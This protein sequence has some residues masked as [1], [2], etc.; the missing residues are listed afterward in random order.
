[1]LQGIAF[2]VY[3][4]QKLEDGYQLRIEHPNAGDSYRV[5][6]QY[7]DG[8]EDLIWNPPGMQSLNF[9]QSEVFLGDIC[10]AKIAGQKLNIIMSEGNHWWWVRWDMKERSQLPL[11]KFSGKLR[12]M[13][14]FDILDEHSLSVVN[15][16]KSDKRITLTMDSNSVLHEDGRPWVEG[17]SVFKNNREIIHLQPELGGET[18]YDDSPAGFPFNDTAKSAIPWYTIGPDG[19]RTPYS[20]KLG[21]PDF[22]GAKRVWPPKHDESLTR[23]NDSGKTSK[24]RPIVSTANSS[25]PAAA[26]ALWS[27]WAG[28]GAALCGAVA[29]LWVRY[30]R[31]GNSGQGDKAQSS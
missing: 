6:L 1:M 10:Y 23:E 29:W 25:D 28:V 2:G 27:L 14:K 7:P 15:Q 19:T 24:L 5:I 21:L 13:V 9:K 22:E 16:G 11:V 26:R 18:V 8:R 3:M 30:H 4:A 12:G 31:G 20:Q 17:Y